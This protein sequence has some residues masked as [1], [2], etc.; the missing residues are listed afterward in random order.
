MLGVAQG[1]LGRQVGVTFQQIQKYERGSTRISCSML[2]RI[3]RVLDATVQDLVDPTGDMAPDAV[4]LLAIFS[5][6]ESES[7]RRA[8]L[9][10]VRI[11][12]KLV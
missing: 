8:V 11:I 12:A 1:E 4:Q 3:A 10:I 2:V 6:I 5:N 9:S 7:G